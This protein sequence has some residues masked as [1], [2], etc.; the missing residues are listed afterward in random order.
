M[1]K[2]AIAA[3]QHKNAAHG[4]SHG[5]GGQVRLAPKGRKNPD[6][7][8]IELRIIPI[9]VAHEIHPGDSIADKLLASIRE[10]RIILRPGDILIVKHKIIS[11]AEGRIV[12]LSTIEARKES[13][14]WAKKYDLDPRVVELALRESRTVIRRKNGVLITETHHGFLCANSGVDVSNVD[15]GSHALLLPEDPDRSATNLR[16]TLKK[17]TGLAIPVII[18]DSFG[19]PWREG[20]TEFAIGLAGMKPLRDDRGRRDSHGYKLKAS[21]EAVADELACAAGLVCGK[22][23]RAPACIVRGFKYESGAGSVKDLLRPAATDLFR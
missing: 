21:M 16:G 20:L 15:G 18:T 3:K 19:R 11:K 22:L 10:R 17:L 7:S 5:S 4:A 14:A 23:N 6:A 8:P 1:S 2:S 12:D 13:I 9:S